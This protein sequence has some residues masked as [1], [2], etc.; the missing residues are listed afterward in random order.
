MSPVQQLAKR[1][2]LHAVPEPYDALCFMALWPDFWH[3]FVVAVHAMAWQV[4]HNDAMWPFT[5][6]AL[7]P[8]ALSPAPG[9]G[10]W[11]PRR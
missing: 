6:S 11:A 10:Q 4:H 3:Q 9:A 8:A 2:R 1:Y 5:L 7:A